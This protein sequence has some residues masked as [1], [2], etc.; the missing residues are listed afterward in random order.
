V[1]FHLSTPESKSKILVSIQVKC[2]NELLRY[3][4]Q[5]VLEREYGPYVVEAEN[6]Y[7]FSVQIDLDNLSEDKGIYQAVM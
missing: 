1:T 2:F 7:N 6:G 5:Q 4:A 3:G